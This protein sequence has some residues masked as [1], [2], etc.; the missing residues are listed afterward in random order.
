M[1]TY[2]A[3]LSDAAVLM[4]VKAVKKLRKS[5]LE[6]S[7][8]KAKLKFLITLCKENTPGAFKCPDENIWFSVTEQ[9][10]KD[11]ESIPVLC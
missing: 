11:R 9:K 1:G 7:V 4:R 8:R 2:H 10:T 6:F 5:E 3:N